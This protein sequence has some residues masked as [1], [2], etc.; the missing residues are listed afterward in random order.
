MGTDRK[1]NFNECIGR[2][3]IQLDGKEKDKNIVPYVK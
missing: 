1:C 3:K 2:S